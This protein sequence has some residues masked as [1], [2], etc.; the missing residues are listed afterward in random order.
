MLSITVPDLESQ[1]H[2][3]RYQVP[4]SVHRH[5]IGLVIIDS[6]AANY[7]AE[8]EARAGGTAMMARRSAEL[9]RLGGLLRD[10]ARTEDVAVVV[11]NQVADRF[12]PASSTHEH[13]IL[14]L[15]YQQ[16]WFTGWGDISPN[17][18]Q[19]LKTPSLGHAWTLQLSARIALLKEPIYHDN[20]NLDKSAS[21]NKDDDNEVVQQTW[22]RTFKVVFAP[23]VGGGDDG[24]G[25]GVE[26]VISAEGI[27]G[28]VKSRT[29][30]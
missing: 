6:V 4:V 11:A 10:L 9:I 21:E 14:S 5:K 20:H 1:D 3:L 18:D 8:F 16:R 22:K 17:Q 28:L 12:M 13:G 2:I 24:N 25:G 30:E 23:W 19:N 27:K 7:R 29:I 26:F 15:D